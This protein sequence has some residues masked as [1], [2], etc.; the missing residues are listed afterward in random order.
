MKKSDKVLSYILTA[1][2]C[3]FLLF[4]FA[5]GSY[6]YGEEPSSEPGSASPDV[7]EPDGNGGAVF[8]LDKN[9][10]REFIKDGLMYDLYPAALSVDLTGDGVCAASDA[11]SILRISAGLEAF[12]D[13]GRIDIN[14]DGKITASDA[15][16]ALRYSAKLDEYYLK[17]DGTALSGAV[18][19]TAGAKYYFS[20]SGVL[21]KSSFLTE[22]DSTYYVD[23]EGKMATGFVDISGSTYYFDLDGK[24]AA[25]LQNI[26]GV[27]Y[28]FSSDGKLG[29]GFAD[30]NGTSYYFG[31]D[32]K[33]FTGD[34]TIDGKSYRFKDGLPVS[35]GWV[36][37]GLNVYYYYP[38][39]RRAQN[40]TKDGVR[41]DANGVASAKT[42]NRDT[43]QIYLR[44]I[45]KTYG[46]SP[47]NIYNYV[48]GNFRYKYYP[49]GDP[50]DMAIRILKNGRGA[51]YD[52]AYLTKYLLEAAGYQCYVI[53]GASFNPNNGNEHDWV[54]VNVNGAWRHI[55]AQRGYYLKTDSEMISAGYKWPTGNFPAAY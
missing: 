21:L 15:R 17:E 4:V 22:G 41:F 52:F 5:V 31:P 44:D 39:G 34:A 28:N 47:K 49:K 40:E 30:Y 1:V 10:P 27:L 6:A 26:D 45:L 9:S 32:G 33:I 24:M 29:A 53:V 43:F 37:E 55:D 54:L 46:S 7:N 38:D 13:T 42:L 20:E 14:G 3:V 51:C 25:G 48:H 50:V 23:A 11:R 2:S 18:L 8:T 16:S 12:G 36:Y 19:D 35:S